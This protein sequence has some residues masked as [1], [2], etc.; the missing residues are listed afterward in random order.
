MAHSSQINTRRS[1]TLGAGIASAAT[2]PRTLTPG[3][4]EN[5]D[6]LR[7]AVNRLLLGLSELP[8]RA[9]DGLVEDAARLEEHFSPSAVIR[10]H[11]KSLAFAAVGAGFLVSRFVLN[12]RFPAATSPAI[13]AARE[14]ISRQV[15][16][17][18]AQAT[19]ETLFSSED[20]PRQLRL[21][22]VS[23][24]TAVISR[25]L[26]EAFERIRLMSS[27]TNEEKEAQRKEVAPEIHERAHT[28][29]SA[30]KVTLSTPEHL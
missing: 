5:G 27:G 26:T 2:I 1:P 9:G 15:S 14:A 19:T 18:T 22:V 24:A 25:V 7:A 12:D 11:P 3:L 17:K 4:A 6:L 21:M 16:P 29:P 10:R 23:V 28:D 20:I 8:Q 13:D 30:G